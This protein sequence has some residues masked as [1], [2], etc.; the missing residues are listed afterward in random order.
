M[1]KNK[2]PNKRYTPKPIRPPVTKGLF[3]EFGMDMHFSLMAFSTGTASLDR[4]KKLAKVVMTV[5]FAT[6][7]EPR[8]LKEHKAAID[9]AVLTLKAI[10]DMNVRTGKWRV[11]NLDLISLTRGVTA[12]DKVLPR[13]DYRRLAQGYTAF[14]NL[15]RLIKEQDENITP[16]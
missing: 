10:S 14:V 15:T 9:S 2:T 11:S 16:N 5:S 7:D 6:D 3:D 8:V 1:A 4:W 13:L 12:I